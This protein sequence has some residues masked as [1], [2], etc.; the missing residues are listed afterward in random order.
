MSFFGVSRDNKG[1]VFF[2]VR[3]IDRLL[4][5]AARDGFYDRNEA[6]SQQWRVTRLE[7]VPGILIGSRATPP[8]ADAECAICLDPLST[9]EC[10]QIESCGHH[11]HKSCIEEWCIPNR[12]TI[13]PLCRAVIGGPRQGNNVQ[14]PRQIVSGNPRPI[15]VILD[16]QRVPTYNDQTPL[17]LR[18]INVLLGD[19]RVSDNNSPPPTYS[20]P[21]IN[22]LLNNQTVP[23][24]FGGD[25]PTRQLQ[26][27]QNRAK[28]MEY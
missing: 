15:N 28:Q 11:F 14:N 1:G 20:R 25:P 6:F 18:P 8:S 22:V 16:N 24:F 2:G 3:H 12:A 17:H 19:Q 7:D 10:I 5:D 27:G 9:L 26:V 23:V 13:C 21:P 4:D